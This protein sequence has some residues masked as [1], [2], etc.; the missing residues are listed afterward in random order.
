MGKT[1]NRFRFTVVDI[2]TGEIMSD[3]KGTIRKYMLSSAKRLCKDLNGNL[4]HKRFIVVEL[5]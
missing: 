1:E 4:S 3:N 5:D 2:N